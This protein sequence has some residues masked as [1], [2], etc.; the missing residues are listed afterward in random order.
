MVPITGIAF[1]KFIKASS[2]DVQPTELI[3][4]KKKTPACNPGDAS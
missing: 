1:P 2:P 4:N 3:L